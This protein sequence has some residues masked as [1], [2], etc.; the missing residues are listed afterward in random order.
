[1]LLLELE[2]ETELRER[3]KGVRIYI[4]HI[5][6]LNMKYY[7]DYIIHFFIVNNI[8]WDFFQTQSIFKNIFFMNIF[9]RKIDL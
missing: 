3:L 4:N 7:Y 6:L 8:M 1:M 2:L 9:K 5:Y